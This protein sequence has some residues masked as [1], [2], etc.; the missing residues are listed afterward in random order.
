[1]KLFFLILE[2]AGSSCCAN[3]GQ[4]YGSILFDDVACSGTE[5]SLFNCNKNAIGSHNCGHNED[6]GLICYGRL[7]YLTHINCKL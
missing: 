2:G 6:A 3:F 7:N 5:S 1:M 4:G